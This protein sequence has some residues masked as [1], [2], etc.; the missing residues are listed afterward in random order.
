M[1]IEFDAAKDEA[2]QAKHGVSLA[3]AE[4][5]DLEGAV[6]FE[7]V[8]FAYGERR[9]IAYAPLH[10]RLYAMCFTVR[11]EA[12]RVIGLRKANQRERKKYERR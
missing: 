9:F 1:K 10:G 8:R 11:G 3:A 6:V 7:D 2:N 5:V 12:I 4:D